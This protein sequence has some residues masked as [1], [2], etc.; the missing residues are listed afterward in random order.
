MLPESVK[1]IESGLPQ[2][3]WYDAVQ[4]LS[5]AD[6]EEICISDISSLR[7]NALKDLVNNA[8]QKR[9]A[10]H[11]GGSYTSPPVASLAEASATGI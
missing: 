6:I 10:G 7:K 5:V 1:K 9:L 2:E 11:L 3:Q 4:N 8:V